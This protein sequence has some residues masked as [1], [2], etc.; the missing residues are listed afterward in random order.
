MQKNGQFVKK[1][2]PP[3]P[4]VD[5]APNPL[6]RT[7]SANNAI[8][9]IKPQNASTLSRLSVTNNINVNG[10][11]NGSINLIKTPVTTSVNLPTAL[12]HTPSMIRHSSNTSLKHSTTIN[13][14][15]SLMNSNI[16]PIVID[17]NNSI[18][19]NLIINNN[20]NNNPNEPPPLADGKELRKIHSN[21]DF[22]DPVCVSAFRLGIEMKYP[23][24]TEEYSK[25][26][27]KSICCKK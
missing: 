23:N 10:N 16:T 13:P 7:N 8:P 24:S 2:L 6:M 15:I 9:S 18:D 4:N 20:N 14:R 21:L 11:T 27:N 3:L 26:R 5:N 1:D 19:N 22:N 12:P 17:G 25:F